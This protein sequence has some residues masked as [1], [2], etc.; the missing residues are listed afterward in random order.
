VNKLVE[1][2]D[3]K[4]LSRL[5]TPY[6]K[7][8]IFDGL[9]APQIF[10]YVPH[11]KL[12]KTEEQ[13]QIVYRESDDGER[14]SGDFGYSLYADPSIGIDYWRGTPLVILREQWAGSASYR[15]AFDMTAEVSRLV[16]SVTR[17]ANEAT[18]SLLRG[19]IFTRT[20]RIEEVESRTGIVDRLRSRR[21]FN[22]GPDS[23][24]ELVVLSAPEGPEPA[25]ATLGTDYRV[26]EN[27]MI[28]E[29]DTDDF[30]DAR[31]TLVWGILGKKKAGR[32]IMDPDRSKVVVRL[33]EGR[34]RIS[35]ELAFGATV[36]D[37]GR[38]AVYRQ[39]S[40][41]SL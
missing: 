9:V 40:D 8:R 16:G 29:Y 15:Q 36:M 27:V 37:S 18:L 32:F 21:D 11:H 22:C 34:A 5:F 6:A 10:N 28:V 17:R 30:E 33:E 14:D 41:S 2:Q 23:T 3:A 20:S 7:T 24:E 12:S 38:I 35:L 26:N 31:G 4:A 19:S 39:T 13:G 1:R 25:R